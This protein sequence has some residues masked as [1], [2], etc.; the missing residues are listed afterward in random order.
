MKLIHQKDN[1]SCGPIAILNVAKLRGHKV[2]VRRHLPIFQKACKVKKYR[3]TKMSDF[4]KIIRKV[5]PNDVVH[6]KNPTL[7]QLNKYLDQKKYVVLAYQV[8]PYDYFHRHFLIIHSRTRCY[9]T[10]INENSQ[11]VA[12]RIHK[13]TMKKYLNRQVYP[14]RIWAVKP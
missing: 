5:F 4:N 3:G 11:V 2:I 7:G 14:V 10:V 8:S 1:I 6:R 9:Y 13:N 12:N